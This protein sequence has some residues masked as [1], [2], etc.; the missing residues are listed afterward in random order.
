MKQKPACYC[1]GKQDSIKPKTIS[2]QGAALAVVDLQ[3][4]GGEHEGAV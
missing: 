4:A 3:Q 1:R 2:I